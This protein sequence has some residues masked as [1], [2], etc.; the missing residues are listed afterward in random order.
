MM[1]GLQAKAF[2]PHL[3][4]E[5]FWRAWLLWNLILS[6]EEGQGHLLAPLRGEIPGHSHLAS[7]LF[8]VKER[9]GLEQPSR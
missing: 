5:A 9:G 3:Q 2:A 6:S 1:P 8:S 7:F 4:E